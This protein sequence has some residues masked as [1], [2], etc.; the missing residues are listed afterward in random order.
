MRTVPPITLLILVPLLFSPLPASAE[1]FKC[2][3][4]EGKTSYSETPCTAAGAKEVLVPIVA[5]P[6]GTPAQGKDWAAENAAANARVKATEAATAAARASGS[7]QKASTPAKSRQ[8]IIAE[9][10]ANHGANCSSAEEIARRQSEDRTLTP[11]EEEARRG[12]VAGRRELERAAEAKEKAKQ[13]DGAP[14]K[15]AK[16]GS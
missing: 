4:A 5:G 7:A 2:T 9:C 15:P 12:A 1:V 8:Q 11:D 6:I 14:A 13:G 10:E 16:T 3:T